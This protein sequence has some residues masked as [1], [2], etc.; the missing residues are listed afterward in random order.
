MKI[1]FFSIKCRRK[2]KFTAVFFGSLDFFAIFAPNFKLNVNNMNDDI[3]LH[4]G[5][6][7]DG[8]LERQHEEIS[9]I[10][11]AEPYAQQ[12]MRM[13]S[14]I[15][16]K[17]P[18]CGTIND[19]E[20]IYCASCGQPI[21]KTSCPNCGA[22]LDPDAD[23]CESC[24]RYIRQD[25]CSFCGARLSG[26]NAFCP[27]C[28]S[29]RGGIVCPVCHTLNDFSFCKQCGTPLTDDACRP[30]TPRIRCSVT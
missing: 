24:R 21:G 11:D 10:R 22:E 12:Q 19:S 16:V 17:C 4:P 8:M 5:R 14:A 29:P 6:P 15:G 2:Y 7:S 27:E 18:H 1:A 23:F 28:G 25:V 26:S 30:R 3:T 9:L 20:A 13:Q